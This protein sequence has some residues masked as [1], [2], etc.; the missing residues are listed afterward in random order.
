MNSTVWKKTQVSLN[1]LKLAGLS[2]G[3][4]DSRVQILSI[5]S[6]LLFDA[7]GID[8]SN[9]GTNTPHQSFPRLNPGWQ[10]RLGQ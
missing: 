6:T 7:K 1:K 2:P 4:S 3:E 9:M 5:T 8:M 10:A